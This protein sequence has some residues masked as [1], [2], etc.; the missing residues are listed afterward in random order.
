ME[1]K[2]NQKNLS[3]AKLKDSLKAKAPATFH[4]APKPIRA[5][6]R[7]SKGG[8]DAIE[9][10]SAIRKVK[11]AE[12]FK[13]II[14]VVSEVLRDK[15]GDLISYIKSEI[16]Q[17]TIRKTYVISKDSFLKLTKIA[18]ELKISRDLLVDKTAKLLDFLL[19][20]ELQERIDKYSK[21]FD[22]AK[23]LWDEA[24]NIWIELKKEVDENDPVLDDLSTMCSAMEHHIFSM[25]DYIYKKTSFKNE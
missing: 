22:R 4:E 24:D 13:S 7:L 6:I 2:N 10:L 19:D 16:K 17:E 21:F 5:T 12:V 15:E 1:S 3:L 8:H 11:N 23:S 18:N 20:N 9:R 25:E 14:L